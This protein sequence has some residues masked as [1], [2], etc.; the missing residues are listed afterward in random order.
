MLGRQLVDAGAQRRAEVGHGLL[1]RRPALLALGG[2]GEQIEPC[3]QIAERGALAARLV[4]GLLPL[5]FGGQVRRAQIRS[6]ALDQVALGA[7][8]EVK[9]GIAPPSLALSG[10]GG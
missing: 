1:E 7:E 10:P 5:R 8:S 6:Q 2:V 3:K 9:V 4:R